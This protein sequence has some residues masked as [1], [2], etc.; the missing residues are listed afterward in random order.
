VS[1][2]EL[3][4]VDALC[5]DQATL[6]LSGQLAPSTIF[7]DQC[8]EAISVS[9]A[10]QRQQLTDALARYMAKLGLKQSK[11]GSKAAKRSPHS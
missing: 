2:Q 11:S 1:T 4:I 3:A 6:R 8:Q 7:T 9:V 10:L 5:E